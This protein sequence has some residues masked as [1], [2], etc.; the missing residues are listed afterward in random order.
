[1]PLQPNPPKLPQL[2]DRKIYKTGQTRGADDDVIFQ[3]RVSRNS[4][5]LIPYD[6]W[7]TVSKPPEGEKQF[8]SGFIAL[9]SPS[10]YFA[11]DSPD[12]VLSN[13]GLKLGRNAL[14]FYQLRSDWDAHPPDSMKW[15]PASSRTNPL[16][17]QF[18]ERIAGTTATQEGER[19]NRGYTTTGCKGAGIRLFEYA[20]STTI[21]LCRIQLEALYWLCDDSVE[22]ATRFGMSKVDAEKRKAFCSKSARD[23]GL[24]D[25]RKLTTQRLINDDGLTICPLCLE[26]LPS[27]G[28]FSRLAQ[29]EGR[30]VHDL[31]VT[32]VNLFHICEVRYGEYN[33][34]PYNL[35]WGHHHCNVVVKDSG[36]AGTLDWMQDI[37]DR[38]VD[39]GL[40]DPSK[41]SISG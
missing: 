6:Y 28:F 41:R 12:A 32:E 21:S 18:V 15:R 27:A 9:I 8:D 36:I 13:R 30:E 37:L 40:Y 34:R 4:T 14:V 1:M 10:S 5:V 23:L 16:R 39:A 35:G 19:I 33:H 26:P 24:L 2:L 38:N 25:Q 20:S 22:T 11:S 17:G 7:D 3:N 29:A 31:T